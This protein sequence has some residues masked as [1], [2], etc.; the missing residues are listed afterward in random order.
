[1]IQP[2]PTNLYPNEYSQ[3]FH[4]YPFAVKLDRCAGSF[5]TLNELSNKVYFPNKIEDVNQGMFNMITGK[6]NQKH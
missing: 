3:E 4:Y 1:M 2:T 5:N 6:T